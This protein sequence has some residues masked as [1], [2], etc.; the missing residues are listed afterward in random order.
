MLSSA[1]RKFGDVFLG[2][3]G[4]PIA[5]GTILQ[6]VEELPSELAS[7]KKGKI[8]VYDDPA[9]GARAAYS[10]EGVTFS[11]Y[12]Y[13]GG[14]EGDDLLAQVRPHFEQASS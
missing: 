3:G 10:G 14:A 5:D 7:L 2:S 1:V 12:A 11:I 13:G 9:L 8:H 6:F 4:A